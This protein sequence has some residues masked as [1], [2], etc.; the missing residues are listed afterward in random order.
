MLGNAAGE[1]GTNFWSASSEPSR[2][3]LA[4]LVGSGITTR[5]MQWQVAVLPGDKGH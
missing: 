1:E 4:Q 5:A 3:A 2:F